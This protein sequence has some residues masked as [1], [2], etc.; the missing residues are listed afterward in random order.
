M[1]LGSKLSTSR[2]NRRVRCDRARI[3]DVGKRVPRPQRRQ[4]TAS[5]VA[6][7]W[8][9]CRE[10]VMGRHQI[11]QTEKVRPRQECVPDLF[12]FK[13]YVSLS[14]TF[15]KPVPIHNFNYKY[16]I[17]SLDIKNRKKNWDVKNKN[18]FYVQQKY[19]GLFPNIWFISRNSG[20]FSRH[21]L[22]SCHCAICTII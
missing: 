18:P 5:S 12:F 3:T 8:E 11:L 14:S 21:Y 1:R 15:E 19:F 16:N 10:A 9:P 22:Q 20:L 6:L 4:E 13:G 2:E 17:C 7:Y